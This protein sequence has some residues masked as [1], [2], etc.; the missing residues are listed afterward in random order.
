MKMKNRIFDILLT[1]VD[2][3]APRKILSITNGFKNNVWLFL[4]ENTKWQMMPVQQEGPEEPVAH[5]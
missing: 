5:D 3:I 4:L 2:I 1:K